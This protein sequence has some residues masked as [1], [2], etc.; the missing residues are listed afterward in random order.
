MLINIKLW[1]IPKPEM[2]IDFL[3]LVLVISVYKNIKI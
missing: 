1:V 3:I 2:F